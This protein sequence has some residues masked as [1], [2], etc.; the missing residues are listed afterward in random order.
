MWL[1]VLISA[2]VIGLMLVVVSTYALGRTCQWLRTRSGL[3]DDAQPSGGFD[4]I[5]K[6]RESTT[7]AKDPDLGIL[8]R[9]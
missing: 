6:D 2:T 8:T 1:Y 4:V 5:V 9:R 3:D 7:A